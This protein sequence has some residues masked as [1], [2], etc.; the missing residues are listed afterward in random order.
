MSDTTG[1]WTRTPDQRRRY[2]MIGGGFVLL[3]A[4]IL[5][6]WS[7]LT[8]HPVPL[9]VQGSIV[10]LGA[11]GIASA[12]GILPVR[13][14]QDYYGGIS[15]VVLSLTAFVASNDLTGMRG[16]AFCPG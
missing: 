3:V 2:D 5:L 9:T 1:T 15:L 14:Q 7:F 6:V 11:L 16:L 10:I 4:L 8:Q 13:N 12:I